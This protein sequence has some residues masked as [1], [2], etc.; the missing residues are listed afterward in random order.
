MDFMSGVAAAKQAYELLKVIKDSHDQ[1]IISKAAGELSEKITELQILNAELSGLYQSERE[2]AVKLREEKAKIE[3]F[4]VKA[5]NYEL[6]TTE[7]GSTVYRSKKPADSTVPHHHLCAHCY[8][9]SVISI[10]QPGISTTKAAGFWVHYCPQCKNE[11]RMTKI[12]PVQ[13]AMAF[14]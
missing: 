3:M 14:Y 5:D 13:P 11:Y 10:L 2:V 7:G 1:S 4:A 9:N 6:Y 12:P 8:N